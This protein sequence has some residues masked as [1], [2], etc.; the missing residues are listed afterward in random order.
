MRDA[1]EATAMTPG[2]DTS[3][4][5][6]LH[7]ASPALPIGSFAYSQGLEQAIADRAV[8]DEASTLIWIG[9]LL[10][11][12]M[13]RQELV[14]WRCCAEAFDARDWVSLRYLNE[15]VLALRETA[16]FRL[17]SRQMGQSMA[18][19]FADWPQAETSGL[20]TT[21]IRDWSYTAAHASLCAAQSIPVS[22]GMTA[23][24]WS[25]AEGQV[26]AAVRHVPL[27][28]SEGQRV[29]HRLKERIPDAVRSALECHPDDLGSASMGLSIASSRH[30]T[31]YSRLFRS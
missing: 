3:L 14:L 12:V 19:L 24:L 20:T 26:M 28:Q 15:R 21:G 5:A 30:E 8:H 25:W 9:D 17:E 16:E 2:S 27:G 6:A 13:A 1:D 10:D 7:L 18:R 4:L 29:L 31:L 22:V 11:L 23:F